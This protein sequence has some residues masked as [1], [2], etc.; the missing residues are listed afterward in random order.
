MIVLSIF[1]T[2]ALSVMLLMLLS[3]LVFFPRL[4]RHPS[5]KQPFVSILIPARNEAAIIGKTISALQAQ[6]YPNYEIMVWDDQSEDDTAL[7]VKALGEHDARVTLVSGDTPQA[8][9]AGKNWACHNLAQHAQGDLLVFTDA[10]VQWQ[11][12][13][14]SS[15]IP[16]QQK[17]NADLLTI[18]PTQQTETWAERL[19]VPLMAFVILGYLQILTV[20]YLPFAIFGAANGQCMLWKKSAYERVGGHEA[21]AS[22][23]LDDVTLA[24][25][26]KSHRL[27][28][29]MA[30]G[31]RLIQTRMYT[32]WPSVRD[33]FAKNILAGYGNSVV[34]LMAA[35]IFHWV[36]FLLPYALLFSAEYQLLA[37]IWI[38][39]AFGLRGLS[40]WYTHQ[41]IGDAVLMPLSVLLMTRIALQAIQW[42]NSGGPRWK[43]RTLPTMP[44]EQIS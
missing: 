20:H 32:D 40:A 1:I 41:R 28:V 10:D 19:C 23:V 36:V 37:L 25:I 6:D 12:K 33:G 18:W 22:R 31:N 21:V 9:W 35:T 30:D 11:P 7:I 39:M 4:Q 8:G 17:T 16:H 24:R 5:L 27:N 3:N 13:A 34:V 42:N 2:G 26:A 14:L 44:Q 43:G 38:A 15:L 29:R